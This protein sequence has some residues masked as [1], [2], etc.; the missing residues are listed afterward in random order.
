MKG[1]GEFS[2]S[3]GVVTLPKDVLE[4]YEPD[5][6]QFLFT[7]TAPNRRFNI[8]PYLDFRLVAKTYSGLT[9]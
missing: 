2:S 3:A 8:P 4:V 1:V 5:V 6:L 9:S 7:G